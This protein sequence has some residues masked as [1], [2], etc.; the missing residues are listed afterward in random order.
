MER[1][2]ADRVLDAVDDG[3][4]EQIK[5]EAGSII[6]RMNGGEALDV[7]VGKFGEVLK[8]TFDAWKRAREIAEKAVKDHESA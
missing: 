3:I 4:I 8:S 1:S 2:L 5:G 7:A 6:F